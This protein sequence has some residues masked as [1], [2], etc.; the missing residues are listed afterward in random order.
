MSIFRKKNSQ[1]FA[2]AKILQ[3]LNFCVKKIAQGHKPGNIQIY[4]TE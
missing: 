4:N 1:N 3:N 2:S